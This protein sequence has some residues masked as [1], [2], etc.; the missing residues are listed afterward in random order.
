[1]LLLAVYPYMPNILKQSYKTAETAAAVSSYPG[2]SLSISSF[3]L[4]SNTR[5][6]NPRIYSNIGARTFVVGEESF[7]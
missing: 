3:H 2:G 1:M 6:R 5:E 4:H 7:R